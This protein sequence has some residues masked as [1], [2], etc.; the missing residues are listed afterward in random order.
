[1][2]SSMHLPK[3]VLPLVL[4]YA[5]PRMKFY[6]EYKQG[7]S[8]LGLANDRWPALCKKLASSEAETVIRAF[9]HYVQVCVATNNL[10]AEYMQ[11]GRPPHLIYDLSK[12]MG[13]RDKEYR[14]FRILL[15]GEDAVLKY[16]AE[17]G[18]DLY[19]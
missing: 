19:A 3:Y 10:N 13:I 2:Q 16:E 7:M 17:C 18:D 15:V 4:A 6:R 5:K 12:Q 8:D 14:A 9:Q 1:M 11:S